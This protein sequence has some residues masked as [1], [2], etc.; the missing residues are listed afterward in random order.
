MYMQDLF[1]VKT[2][3]HYSPGS[4]QGSSHLVQDLLEPAYLL[5]QFPEPGTAVLFLSKRVTLLL[6]LKGTLKCHH[7]KSLFSRDSGYILVPDP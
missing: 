6:I 4:S 2:L 7:G 3:G 1:K 5:L